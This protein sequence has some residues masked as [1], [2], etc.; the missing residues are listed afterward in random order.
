MN[1]SESNIK[2][3]K[4]TSSIF[5][6]K[7]LLHLNRTNFESEEYQS[8]IKQAN[9]DWILKN[10]LIL[11]Q[12]RLYV[13]LNENIQTHFLNEAHHQISTAHSNQIKTRKLID[14]QYF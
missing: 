13:S 11:Y 3:S 7:W 10:E 9:N 8:K 4:L 5:L 14:S 6:I 12:K 1:N 2:S